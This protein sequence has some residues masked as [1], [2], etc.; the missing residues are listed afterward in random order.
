MKKLLLFYYKSV[1]RIKK[2]NH[3]F[4]PQRQRGCG[5]DG[6]K[7]VVA[8]TSNT[9]FP[10]RWNVAG[11]KCLSIF[12]YLVFRGTLPDQWSCCW[13]WFGKQKN[14][15]LILDLI[16]QDYNPRSIFP[17]ALFSAS[18]CWKS[19]WQFGYF[20]SCLQPQEETKH[21]TNRQSIIF[22]RHK[23]IATCN[24][25]QGNYTLKCLCI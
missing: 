11:S 10:L 8:W 16:M 19:V 17:S 13:Y 1:I 25:R 22:I 2:H 15:C 14:T 21:T 6:I 9:I 12:S 18:N 3:I 7:G 23:H 20:H 4:L 24:V 5:G